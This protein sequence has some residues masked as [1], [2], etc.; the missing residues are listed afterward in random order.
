MKWWPDTCYCIIKCDAPSKDGSFVK[1]CRLH[2]NTRKTT[3][4]YAH[5]LTNRKKSSETDDKAKKR[6]SEI[7]EATRT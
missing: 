2:Q 4:V 7:K 1:R 6:K 5:N 3:D